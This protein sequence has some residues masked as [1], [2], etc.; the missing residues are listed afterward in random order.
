MVRVLLTYLIPFLLPLAA[1]M[2]WAWYRTAHV[3]KHGGESPTIEKGPWP[4]LLLLGAVLAV[5]LMGTMALFQ[6]GDPDSTYVPP[7]YE[8]GKI[9]PGRLED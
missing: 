8:D 3:K 6:G 2:A 9:V 4:I 7:R 1:Y 5:G